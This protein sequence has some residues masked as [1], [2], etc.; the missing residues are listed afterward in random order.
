LF[1]NNISYRD[2]ARSIILSVST[3][4]LGNIF[5]YE[6]ILMLENREIRIKNDI[7]Q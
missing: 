2:L 6:T 5:Y 7:L 4:I 3:N 1:Y